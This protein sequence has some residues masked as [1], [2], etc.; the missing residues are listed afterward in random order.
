MKGKGKG[1]L[2]SV[3]QLEA[4][5]AGIRRQLCRHS[6]TRGRSWCRS[7]TANSEGPVVPVPCAKEMGILGQLNDVCEVDGCCICGKGIPS[8]RSDRE[9]SCI[10][11]VVQTQALVESL[12]PSCRPLGRSPHGS[13]LS[14]PGSDAPVDPPPPPSR[15]FPGPQA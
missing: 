14:P 11:P 9:P 5:R 8:S 10:C 4:L 13:A 15:L 1:K 6:R 2:L 7:T 3:V 12:S